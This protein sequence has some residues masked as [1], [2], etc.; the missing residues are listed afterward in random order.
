MFSFIFSV[1]AL[2][3]SPAF[4][5]EDDDGGEILGINPPMSMSLPGCSAGLTPTEARQGVLFLGGP[6]AGCNA[7][8]R[9]AVIK[10]TSGGCFVPTNITGFY[11]PKVVKEVEGGL[12]GTG[13]WM[14]S[15]FVTCIPSGESAYTILAQNE[16]R[17]SGYLIGPTNPS[18]DALPTAVNGIVMMAVNYLEPGVN[19]MQTVPAEKYAS[20]REK[21]YNAQSP[22]TL[23][24]GRGGPILVTIES[25][26]C[27]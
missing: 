19:G 26:D 18:A 11:T 8:P 20:C 10:N 13:A 7:H 22:T 16:V 2:V 17:V 27:H 9:A 3:S 14:P 24:R 23:R 5:H 15:K 4:A 6:K 25:G 21:A 1:L 12:L